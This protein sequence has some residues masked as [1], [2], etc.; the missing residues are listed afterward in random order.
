MPPDPSPKIGIIDSAA[1]VQAYRNGVSVRALSISLRMPYNRVRGMI[2]D[3]GERPRTRKES[4][5]FARTPSKLTPEQREALT[6]ELRIGIRSHADLAMQYGISRERVRQ[7]AVSSGAP[8]GREI[9]QQLTHGKYLELQ[10]KREERAQQA[11]EY[12]ECVYNTWRKLW[13]E[14]K[15]LAEMGDLLRISPE[16]V[17]VR[18]AEL[19]KVHPDWFPHRRRIT[20]PEQVERWKAWWAEGKHASVIARLENLQTKSVSAT[21][22]CLRKKHPDWFPALPRKR[23]T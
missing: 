16:T 21:I 22:R 18:L 1:A 9:Q 6:S 7:I 10:R 15:T 13:A 8:S 11:K 23:R 3:A 17:G 14:G 5:Q 2:M 12:R 19:R 20:T 4:H